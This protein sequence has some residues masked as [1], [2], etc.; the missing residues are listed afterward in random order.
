MKDVYVYDHIGDD[1]WGFGGSFSA[2]D[3]RDALDEAAGDDV[4]V[5]V[6]SGGGDVFEA[7][8]IA[9]LVTRYRERHPEARV[10]TLVDGLA[11]SAASYLG[12]TADEV[13]VAPGAMMM[14]H[15]PSGG[16]W[17]Q[18]ADMRRVAD[19]LDSVKESIVSLYVAKAGGT[20]EG[21]A[22]TMAAETWMTAEEAVESGLADAI[23]Y[24]RNAVE[25]RVAPQIVASWRNAPERF[26]AEAGPD[27]EPEEAAGDAGESIETEHPDTDGGAGAA[28]AA[29]PEA[30]AASRAV[31]VGGDVLVLR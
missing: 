13:L 3:M 23:A 14:V 2:K 9:S 6:N 18:A 29:E 8:A 26:R 30:E 1:P 27:P 11:A 21:W 4:T 19:S 25:A 5:H 12:L 22:E 24:D 31:V 16:C 7:T 15:D 28:G 17:G 20:R 10:T